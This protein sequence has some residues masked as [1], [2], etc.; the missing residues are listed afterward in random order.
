L[1]AERHRMTGKC[2][3]LSVPGTK[4]ALRS[5]AWPR[6][7]LSD[8]PRD[9]RAPAPIDIVFHREQL[10]IVAPASCRNSTAARDGIR[11]GD[12]SGPDRSRIRAAT[13]LDSGRKESCGL[14][15]NTRRNAGLSFT[16]L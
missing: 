2:D 13:S 7:T 15:N 14:K 5:A 12:A 9:C 10:Y 3:I 16:F 4:T 1:L 8:C 11:S 6:Q